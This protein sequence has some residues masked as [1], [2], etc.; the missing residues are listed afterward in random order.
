MVVY[1]QCRKS[2][3][4]IFASAPRSEDTTTLADSR[5]EVQYK[6]IDRDAWS[7]EIKN[8]YLNFVQRLALDDPKDRRCFRSRPV[9]TQPMIATL[10][11]VFL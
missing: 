4:D 7:K 5:I 8:G 2:R 11:S 3:T 9:F 10:T 1:R 6:V